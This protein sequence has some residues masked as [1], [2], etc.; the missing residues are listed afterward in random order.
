ML[1]YAVLFNFFVGGFMK[2]YTKWVLFIFLAALLA[3]ILS[4]S[5]ERLLTSTSY[6]GLRIQ[7][8]YLSGT[9]GIIFMSAAV[10]A[11]ARISF[12]NNLLGG[13]DKAYNFHKL[14]AGLGFLFGFIHYIISF[15]N[16]ML[17]KAGIIESPAST[18][19][20]TGTILEIYKASYAFLEPAFIIMIIVV[21]IAAYRKIP[22]HIFQY[23]H[24]LI[25]LLYLFVAF[26]AF[27][28][29]FRGGWVGTVGGVILHAFVIIGAVCAVITLFQ[30]TGI[31]KRFNG[32]VKSIKSIQTGIIE[33]KISA[34][35]T[36]KYKAGQFVFLK[37]KFSFEPH[38]F[39]IASYSN[40]G[41]LTFYIKESGDFTNKITGSVK[42]V[43]TV[44]VEGPYGQFTFDDSNKNQL[45]IAGG[46]GITPFI[47]ALENLSLN[48]NE[49]NITLIFSSVGKSP[50]DDK[51]KSLCSKSNVK[52]ILVDTNKDGLLT[53]DKIK[54]LAPDIAASSIWFCGPYGF[55]RC[56]EKGLKADN[57]SIKNLHYDSFTFR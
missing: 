14:S 51:I 15:S 13:L 5:L 35:D 22:Y 33:I 1:Q 27:A 2:N 29:I 41:I 49:K 23:T 52:L 54:S 19:H 24:K 6:Y 55:R 44:R 10:I 48:K 39:S 20:L 57:I 36:F 53:Y 32:T 37:F 34:P 11:S 9:L 16:K 43:D 45:W 38:P 31:N 8:M 21:F 46:I 17:I 18:N 25:P 40:D 50:F 4:P 42:E 30:L 26:H 47:A 3:F 28:T 12:I 7:I 56:V